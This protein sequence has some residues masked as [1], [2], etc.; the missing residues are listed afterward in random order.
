MRIDFPLY[1]ANPI[2]WIF[3]VFLVSSGFI[4]L[5]IIIFWL[6]F[7][8]FRL[9]KSDRSHTPPVSVIIAARNE[10]DNIY[11]NLEL[12]LNQDYPEFEVIV[13]NHQSVDNSKNIFIALQRIYKHLRVVEIEK[14]RH[15]K[16]GKK[17]PIT[18]GIKASKYEHLLFTDADCKPVSNQWIRLMAENFSEKKDIVLGYGPYT[19]EEGFLN[20]LIRFDTIQIAINYFS[21]AL[22]GLPYMGVGR[23][24]AYKKRRFT[25]IG[26]FKS[27]YGIASGD[28]DLFIRDAA[29]RKNVAVEIR[30]ESYCYSDSKKTW[31]D[32]FKQKRRHY[33]TS[34]EYKVF[35]KALLGIFPMML[36]IQLLTFVSLLFFDDYRFWCIVIFSGM[37][38]LRWVTQVFNFSK[39]KSGRLALFYPVLEY[40]H[41]AVTSFM[42]YSRAHQ[43][44][45][46]K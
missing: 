45:Q 22:N 36:V 29:T 38:V 5:Y 24:L 10:E 9:P 33:S 16:V 23:N 20:A 31:A 40:I 43:Q 32:W 37:V 39:L 15:L 17:L 6:R 13:V 7:A 28:D 42:Y 26:G 4:F 2:Y 11:K 21:F 18:L 30:P 35:I 44:D 14:N 1:D 41:I 46:W 19:K 3:I 12:I 27:H 8:L 25:E 34:G